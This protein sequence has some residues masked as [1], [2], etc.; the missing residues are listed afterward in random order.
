[1]EPEEW[2]QILSAAVKLIGFRQLQK[3]FFIYRKP[4]DS[5]WQY[6]RCIQKN[7]LKS[8]NI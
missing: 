1:M 7:Y 2:G 4:T 8:M 5:T 6:P 3:S